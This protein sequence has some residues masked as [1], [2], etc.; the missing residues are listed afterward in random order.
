MYYTQVSSYTEF[1]Y[2]TQVFAFAQARPFEF[3]I[4]MFIFIYTIPKLYKHI[5]YTFFFSFKV[6]NFKLKFFFY[7]YI[8]FII[9]IFTSFL[10]YPFRNR[11]SY[12]IIRVIF[13]YKYNA[14]LSPT[15]FGQEKKV[16]HKHSR[17]N[18]N[19]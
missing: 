7:T 2:Y 5:N 6:R 11:S 10:Y 3:Y 15:T 16:K 9:Y 13:V 17:G 8:R 18:K 19:I 12:M 1:S 14:Y 4:T